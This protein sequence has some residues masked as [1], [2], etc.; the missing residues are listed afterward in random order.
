[1]TLS[2]YSTSSSF[3]FLS[4]Y[5]VKLFSVTLKNSLCSNMC[6]TLFLDTGAKRQLGSQCTKVLEQRDGGEQIWCTG[7][8]S[9][10]REV[11]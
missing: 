5:N 1:M 3:L 11:T 6:L 10:E 8:Q 9:H 2:S 4:L 7:S